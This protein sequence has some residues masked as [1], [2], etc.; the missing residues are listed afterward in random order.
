MTKDEKITQVPGSEALAGRR[1][2]E[3]FWWARTAEYRLTHHLE[4]SDLEIAYLHGF[5]DAKTETALNAREASLGN[6][7]I[8][9]HTGKD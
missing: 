6:Q 9:K 4:K 2:F 5:C 7:T 3:K 1:A 8:P